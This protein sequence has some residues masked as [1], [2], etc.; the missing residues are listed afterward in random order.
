MGVRESDLPQ[1]FSQA[2]KKRAA[3]SSVRL[4]RREIE[5]L[6]LKA[7]GHSSKDAAEVLVVSKRTVD[8]HLGNAYDKLQVNN[9]V[10]ACRAATRL[11]LICFE[12]EWSQVRAEA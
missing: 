4:T 9:L 5:V 7:I 1:T 8:F 3:T 11:G 10:Q 6:G 12:P 2:V